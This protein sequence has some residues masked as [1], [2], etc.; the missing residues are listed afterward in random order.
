[1]EGFHHVYGGG[2]GGS[3]DVHEEWGGGGGGRGAMGERRM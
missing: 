2:Q 3:G 1:M